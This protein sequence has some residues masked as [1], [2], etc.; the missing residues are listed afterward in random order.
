MCDMHLTRVTVLMDSSQLTTVALSLTSIVPRR[1]LTSGQSLI[2]P[3]CGESQKHKPILHSLLHRICVQAHICRFDRRGE[4]LTC[5]QICGAANALCMLV[6]EPKSLPGY[7]GV[8]KWLFGEICSKEERCTVR[9]LHLVND[10]VTSRI[11]H[12]LR[13]MVHAE[14]LRKREDG[15]RSERRTRLPP[16]PTL[17]SEIKSD[18]RRGYELLCSATIP[19]YSRFFMTGGLA[20]AVRQ[21]QSYP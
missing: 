19:L 16:A 13:R 2:H 1:I 11:L 6:G 21:P 15:T 14:S 9:C 17:A 12:Q 18:P 10:S 3:A 20:M 5:H 7:T 4:V 8:R